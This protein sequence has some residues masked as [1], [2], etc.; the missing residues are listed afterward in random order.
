MKRLAIISTIITGLLLI[1]GLADWLTNYNWSRTTRT[2]CS[3]TR[4]SCSTTGPRCWSPS[5]S[6]PS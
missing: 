3:A 1:L 6:W 5:P 2:R 4:T